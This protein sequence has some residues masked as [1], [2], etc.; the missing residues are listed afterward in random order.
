[1]RR[2]AI[3]SLA[4]ALLAAGAAIADDK[5][6][7]R[8]AIERWGKTVADGC[9]SVTDVAAA[10]RATTGCGDCTSLVKGLIDNHCSAAEPTPQ[11]PEEVTV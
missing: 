1:M 2:Q 4:L 3:S 8:A 10:T 6:D 5:A 11:A 7:V 9:T